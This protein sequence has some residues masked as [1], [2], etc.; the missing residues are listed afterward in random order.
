MILRYLM[1]IANPPVGPNLQDMAYPQ[2]WGAKPEELFEGPCPLCPDP[3]QIQ[4]RMVN[5][6]KSQNG[7]SVLLHGFFPYLASHD[8]LG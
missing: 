4:E 2:S 8:G 3:N 7:L 5:T 1:D 6:R